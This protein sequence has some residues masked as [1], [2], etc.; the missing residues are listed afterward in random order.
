MP[1]IALHTR[2]IV[3]FLCVSIGGLI[4]LNRVFQSKQEEIHGA[5]G[6]ME[7]SE[8]LRGV[9]HFSLQDSV[10]AQEIMREY[11]AAKA[12]L[13]VSL[14][15][16]RLVTS[17]VLFFVIIASSTIFIIFIIRI[18]KPL[19]ELKLATDQ[20]RQGNFSVHLP[21][22]GIPEMRELKNSFNVMSRELEST[23]NK[24]LVAEKEMIWKDLSRIL[25]HEIKNPLTPIQLVIQRLEERFQTD[26]DS[27][28]DILPESISIIT[29]EIENLRLLAQDF[30]NYAKVSQPARELF[31]PAGSIREIVKSYAQNYDIRLELS[32]DLKINFDKTHFYQVL[33]NI[34]QNAIDASPASKPITIKLYGERSYVV[35]CIQDQ[36]SGIDGKDI[37]RIFEPYFSKKTKG[38]GLG[39]ALV[40]KLC[41]ANGTIVRVKSKPQE[42]TDFTLIIEETTA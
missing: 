9:Q 36:G 2:I 39:L 10:K 7:L 26:P 22:T 15:D 14:G 21:E 4:L 42:G 18:S 38:T 8:R 6:R 29:Q 17:V 31:N 13:N 24:L 20:I 41:D 1:R 33:T 32:E 12:L 30:S 5:I 35:L 40:K 34:L 28:K 23:Q 37:S 27:V 3:L 16:S 25:A 11:D 19:R